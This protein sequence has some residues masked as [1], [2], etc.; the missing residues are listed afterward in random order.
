L[1]S[2]GDPDRVLA[3]APVHDDR[4]LLAAEPADHVLRAYDGAQSLGEETEQ[5]VADGVAVDV[6]DVLEVVDVEHQH[7]E[8]PV[9][10]AR[11]LQRLEEPL[12]EDAVVEE[13]RQRVGAG[14]VLETLA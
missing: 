9:G 14:M 3:P 7:R 1:Y 5:L 10:A 6:V 4:E 12:V 11:L 13:P 2:V 8:G